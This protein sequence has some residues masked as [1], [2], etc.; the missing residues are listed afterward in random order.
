VIHNNS[1]D[2]KATWLDELVAYTMLNI[3]NINEAK[4]DIKREK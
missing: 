1:N 4:T 3:I 2:R